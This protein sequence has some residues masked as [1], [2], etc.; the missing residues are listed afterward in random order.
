M[1]KCPFCAEK[2]Q[3]LSKKCRYCWE[4]LKNFKEEIIYSKET[5]NNPSHIAESE[6]N[7][8]N[9][10]KFTIAS[11][12]QRLGNH[13]I[14]TIA[15][16]LASILVSLLFTGSN[17]TYT[18]DDTWY[19]IIYIMFYVLYYAIFESSNWKTLGK[20]ITKTKVINEYWEIPTFFNSLWRTL[21]RYIPFEGLSFL[22]SSNPVGWHDTISKTLV[23]EDKNN[24]D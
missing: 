9:D 10:N 20:L 21:C 3:D 2:I 1:K 7:K 5:Q 19:T 13:I 15:I 16:V 4:W 18:G 23:V 24:L 22:G 11:W 17:S 6:N 12:Q 8:K 14:D